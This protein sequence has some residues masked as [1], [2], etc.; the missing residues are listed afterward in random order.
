VENFSYVLRKDNEKRNNKG[1]YNQNEGAPDLLLDTVTIDY[2]NGTK[3]EILNSYIPTDEGKRDQLPTNWR[4][5][6]L[7]KQESYVNGVLTEE[8]GFDYSVATG[9]LREVQDTTYNEKGDVVVGETR[10]IQ[11]D[12][13]YKETRTRLAQPDAEGSNFAITTDVVQ[14]A[15]YMEKLGW[16]DL[17][18]KPAAELPDDEKKAV[19][20]FSTTPGTLPPRRS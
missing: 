10:F 13:L 9:E 16:F 17:K 15:K 1:W 7:W 20:N 18:I 2:N 4:D 19:M 14:N 8:L 6:L 12:N 3:Q 5:K 11:K